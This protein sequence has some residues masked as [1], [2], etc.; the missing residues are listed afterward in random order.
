MMD[1]EVFLTSRVREEYERTGDTRRAVTRGRG[2][3]ARARRHTPARPPAERR[4]MVS[5]GHSQGADG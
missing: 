2:S 4:F 1:Y 5:L 3:L